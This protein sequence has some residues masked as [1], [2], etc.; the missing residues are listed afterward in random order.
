MRRKAS[1]FG[2]L[3]YDVMER[4][5]SLM[6]DESLTGPD[7]ALGAGTEA[8]AAAAAPAAQDAGDCQPVI[9]P[10]QGNTVESCVISEW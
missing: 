7:A 10:R 9:M 1:S 6:L 8:P 4:K 3:S 5:I 2:D